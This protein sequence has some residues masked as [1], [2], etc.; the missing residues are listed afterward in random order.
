MHYFIRFLF[1]VLTYLAVAE[2]DLVNYELF[3]PENLADPFAALIPASD[4]ASDIAWDIP[5]EEQS[6]Q[7]ENASLDIFLQL[8]E[9]QTNYDLFAAAAGCPAT[10]R[11]GARD[12]KTLLC[13]ANQD[14]LEIPELPTLNQL[15]NDIDQPDSP[16][17]TDQKQQQAPWNQGVPEPNSGKD[18]YCPRKK[19][20]HLCCICDGHFSFTFCQDCLP[21]KPYSYSIFFKLA[22]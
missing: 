7:D 19:S 4:P 6:Q 2:E 5:N 10:D 3:L 21:G 8:D 12:E 13:P 17:F 11:L 16:P 9:D 14:E 18:G 15:W 1:I 20:Y 22:N